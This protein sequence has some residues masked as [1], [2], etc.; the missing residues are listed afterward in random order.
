VS[1]TGVAATGEVGTPSIIGIAN[2]TVT[3]VQASGSVNSVIVSIPDSTDVLGVAA[4]S[5]VGSVTI[6][7]TAN[8]YPDGLE[9]VA[10]VGDVVVFA[11]GSVILVGL[12][13]TATVGAATVYLEQRVIVS[14]LSATASVG[15]T[16]ED[17]DSIVM[18]VGI[19]AYGFVSATLVWG[20]IVPDQDPNYIDVMSGQP[21]TFTPVPSF[22]DPVYVMAESYQE[23]NWVTT[24]TEGATIVS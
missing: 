14:G 12:D 19:S 8:I 22:N 23:P 5:N 16:S 4:T 6:L 13:A 15:D 24:S 10:T 7:S 20:Q 3:G 11:D 17:A 2:L 9:A 18:L 21:T 1:P